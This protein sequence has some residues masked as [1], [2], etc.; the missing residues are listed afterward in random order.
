[1][2][3]YPPLP[4]RKFGIIY[5]DPPWHYG[6]EQHNGQKGRKTGGAETHYPTISLADLKS[7]D[8]RSIAADD[9]LLFMW[10]SSPHLE[11]AIDLGKAWGFK[12]ATIGFVWNKKR[13]NPGSYTMSQCELCLIFKKGKI[14]TPRGARNV[15]QYLSEIRTEHSRKPAEVKLRIEAMFPEHD[16]VELFSRDTVSTGWV[17]WGD[18]QV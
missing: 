3:I 14:P 17:L 6:K 4:D 1:M 15:R 12:W 9:C 18:R 11:Q 7:L 2:A 16:K 5:A 10:T 8:V 13:V